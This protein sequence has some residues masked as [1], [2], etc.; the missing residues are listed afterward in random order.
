MCG[1]G[2]VIN[3]YRC[4]EKGEVGRLASFVNYRGPDNCGIRILDT[5]LNDAE[6]GSMALFFN[7]L[8]IIDLDARSNQPF[9]DEHHLLMFNGEIYN[10]HELKASLSRLGVQF[11]TTSDTEVLFHL[12]KIKGKKALSELNGMFAFFWIDKSSKTFIAGR[13]RLGIK[14]F[15][16]CRQNES[17][18]FG[19]ELHSIL[20]L[21]NNKPEISG[22]AVDMYLWMQ[23]VPTPH[24]IFKNIFKL[25]PGHV[26]SGSTEVSDSPIIE[27]FWDAYKFVSDTKQGDVTSLEETLHDSIGRQLQADVPL[28]LFLSSGVDSSLLAAM[29]NKYFAKEQDVNFFTVSFSEATETDESHDA[30][31]FIKG[32]N[33]HHLKNHLLQVDPHFLS[34]HIADLYNFYD[35]PFGDY[36]ALLNW[37]ISSKAK[38]HVTVAISGDGAD[39]LFWG[40]ER[41]NKWQDLQKL[42][43]LPVL[44]E[45]IQKSASL[46]AGTTV[47]RKIKKVFNADPVI[48][49][50]DLFLLP[51]FRSYFR[52]RPITSNHLWAL[53][54][55]KLVEQRK[56]LPAVLDLKTY[57][58]DAMLYK[59]DRSSM[60]T[61]LEVRVPYL[62]N[63]VLE[64]ALQ[65]DLHKKS[66]RQFRNKAVLKEL[67]LKLAPHYNVNRPKKGFSFPLKKWLRENWRDQVRELVN[68]N[69][70]ISCGLEPKTFRLIVDHFYEKNTNSA[71]EVWYLFN[72]AL[73]KQRFD[74][75]TSLQ[76]R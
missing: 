42:N 18:Y 11:H 21:L 13:D 68:D 50:F 46:I 51:A 43:R 74:E 30:A 24:T 22:D 16:Y 40:Y 20:R 72:L 33:N 34:T 44:S 4:L 9:E 19:S 48:R 54:H 23:Y 55:I 49:H 8:A 32:F 47:G 41:Y 28:G 35:E 6:R 25:P 64:Y 38:E 14:P 1:F 59:V 29:V 15:Y 26:I 2:G 10:Y 70:L 69:M 76:T 7:R 5:S 37:V 12:L 31:K 36:A 61:S 56:D 65:L 60:A 75:M 73:W 71:V 62:D 52:N 45:S 27:E 58:A 67:L 39:E 66:N 3:H 17:F 63:S 53:E 57:L